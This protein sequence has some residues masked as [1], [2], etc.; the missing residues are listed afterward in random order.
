MLTRI[1]LE[2]AR[3]WRKPP[4]SI[5]ISSASRYHNPLKVGMQVSGHRALKSATDCV[6]VY[7]EWIDLMLSGSYGVRPEQPVQ[8]E[9]IL[10]FLKDKDLVCGCKPGEACHGDVLLEY[11]NNDAVARRGIRT[12][13]ERWLRSQPTMTPAAGLGDLQKQISL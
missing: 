6:R 9:K 3:G 5:L 12:A 10:L 4:G 7:R 1:R 2:H 11:A 8:M 13:S